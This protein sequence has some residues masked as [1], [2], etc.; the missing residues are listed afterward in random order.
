MNLQVWSVSH[1]REQES[2]EKY[3]KLSDVGREVVNMVIDEEY[4]RLERHGWEH[5]PC[6]K[7]GERLK[8][9]GFILQEHR[10]V[11]YVPESSI[12]KETD[13]C[14]QIQIDR[15]KPIFKKYDIVALERRPTGHNEMGVFCLNDACYIR[16]LYHVGDER[17]LKSLN[18]MDP[19]VRVTEDDDFLCFG[20]ILGKVQGEYELRTE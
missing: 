6:W 11:L 14:F 8:N 16:R 1:Q 9:S 20:T 4:Q 7:P 15:Y 10:H 17:I 3:R 12:P 19:D 18:V 13:F 5:Y 2:I